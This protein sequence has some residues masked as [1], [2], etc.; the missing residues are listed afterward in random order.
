MHSTDFRA[1]KVWQSSIDFTIKIYDVCR[2]FPK[3]EI[4]G[5]TSQIKRAVVSISSNIAEGCGRETLKDFIH[6]LFIARGSSYEV[7]SHIEICRRLDFI[8]E[9]DYYELLRDVEAIGKMV[10]GLIKHY[11]ERMRVLSSKKS[12]IPTS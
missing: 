3:D 8:S 11:K 9:K 4:F 7:S 12:N 5:M 6:F 2:N 1:L 10:N